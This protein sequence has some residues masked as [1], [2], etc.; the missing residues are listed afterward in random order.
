MRDKVR[1][2]PP[3]T[4]LATFKA[5]YLW[6]LRACQVES[7]AR[8]ESRQDSFGYE[9]DDCAGSYEP[10]YERNNRNEQCSTCGKCA[11]ARGVTTG[12]SSQRG[13]NQ[14]RDSRGYTDGC[15]A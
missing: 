12:E 4:T 5:K 14:K 13:A 2:T 3:E 1:T 9:V 11:E 8:F 15:V 10:R 7:H 6:Q